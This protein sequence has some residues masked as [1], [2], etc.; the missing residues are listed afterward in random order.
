MNRFPFQMLQ[1]IL[2]F[3]FQSVYFVDKVQMYDKMNYNN[4]S[5]I[6]TGYGHASGI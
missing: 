2:I 4:E 1:L 5:I 6:T 3:L